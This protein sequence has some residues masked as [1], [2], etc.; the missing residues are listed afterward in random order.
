MESNPYPRKLRTNHLLEPLGRFLYN[1]NPADFSGPKK[2]KHG[3]DLVGFQQWMDSM[4]LPMDSY[5]MALPDKEPETQ[6]VEVAPDAYEGCN[7]TNQTVDL[8][9]RHGI[10]PWRLRS[11]LSNFNGRRRHEWLMSHLGTAPAELILDGGLDEKTVI[12]MDN[13]RNRWDS[14][15]REKLKAAASESLQDFF[16]KGSW[17]EQKSHY[18]AL[19]MDKATSRKEEVSRGN[20]ERDSVPAVAPRRTIGKPAEGPVH[21][22]RIPHPYKR[23]KTLVYDDITVIYKDVMDRAE[24]SQS[25]GSR[26]PANDGLK[27]SE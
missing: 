10:A 3:N 14:G 15:T 26:S 6:A 5:M 2:D 7:L 13:K 27:V 1:G 24:I 8:L 18:E 16:S 23:G 19:A 25:N 21:T 9:I 11:N 20:R 17:E 4:M 22:L 12:G